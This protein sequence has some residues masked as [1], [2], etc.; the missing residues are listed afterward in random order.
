MQLLEQL[1]I[2]VVV[3]LAAT[4]SA[5]SRSARSTPSNGHSAVTTTPAA[6][7]DDDYPTAPEDCAGWTQCVKAI[8]K[9]RLQCQTDMAKRLSA[10]H[11]L[12]RQPTCM[13][14]FNETMLDL[15]L[16]ENQRVDYQLAC[17]DSVKEP[18]TSSTACPKMATG[19]DGGKYVRPATVMTTAGASGDVPTAQQVDQTCELADEKY[20]ECDEKFSCTAKSG[21]CDACVETSHIARW[22]AD[23]TLQRYRTMIEPPCDQM[24]LYEY[25]DYGDDDDDDA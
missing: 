4:V 9:Y 6:D 16:L 15:K 3:M 18:V 12:K 1:T 2:T 17:F 8:S 23:V 13:T 25:D 7:S 22:E 10:E 5:R 11:S 24:T 21:L 19:G 14:A 20:S